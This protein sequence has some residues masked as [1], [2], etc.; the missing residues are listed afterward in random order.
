MAKLTKH[1]I[2]EYYSDPEVQS[3]I[4]EQIRNRPLLAVQTLDTGENV[5]RRKDPSGKPILITKALDDRDD[6]NDLAW[7]AAR[8]FSEFHPVVGPK[9][10]TA[11]IDIDP[12]PGSN[13]KTLKSTVRD[14]HDLLRQ[15]PNVK[16]TQISYSGGRG[17]HVRATL[18]K[19]T[20]VDAL[21]N[22]LNRSIQ[23]TFKD[24]TDVVN[25]AK[26]G[27]GQI[28]LDTSTLKD[29]GSIRAVHSINSETGRIAVPVA[30]TDL[31][32]FK[33]EDADLRTFLKNKEFAPGI[34]QSKKTHALPEG[35][36]QTWTMAVQEH[37]AR[38]AGP[39]WDMRLV[40]PHTGFAHSWAVPKRTFPEAGGK[41]LLAVQTPTHS[42]Q[43]ALT[44]GEGKPREIKKGYG[45]GQV[46]LK[47]KEPIK[48]LS[49]DDNR[50]KFQR[51][52]GESYTLFR[53]KDDTW[54]LRNS[55]E[56]KG[57]DMT[58]YNLGKLAALNKFGVGTDQAP[59]SVSE[60]QLP[61][62]TKDQNTPV[63]LLTNALQEISDPMGKD[64]RSSDG[65]DSVEDR[66]NRQTSWSSPFTIPL[67][68]ASG[69]SPVWP[70][71]GI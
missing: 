52:N 51:D 24:R 67:N 28:R 39:H 37:H 47:H 15:M 48:V 9:T 38:K 56:K 59:V 33:P 7:Y 30:L 63:G 71:F 4:L 62:D 27:K 31:D 29:T 14:A 44:F 61:L 66:L 64:R 6:P 42:S 49:V 20:D 26:P 34:P 57:N 58:P 19:S 36:D 5:Y 54:L 18:D 23:K 32:A 16:D 35:E 1:E 43:Y 50:I 21:R 45:A 13:A 22:R 41:P 70:G 69:P 12:G 11:W 10:T 60:A 2:D 46:E 17:Y 40:D 53:T 25:S 3:K 55:T 65:N 8:R 68:A